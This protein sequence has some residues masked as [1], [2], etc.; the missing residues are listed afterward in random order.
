MLKVKRKRKGNVVLCD[1]RSRHTTRPRR[2]TKRTTM[3]D[4]SL[5]HSLDEV[6]VQVETRM[7]AGAR[8]GNKGDNAKQLFWGLCVGMGEGGFDRKRVMI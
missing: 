7:V 5:V 1:L 2:A 8:V 4:R 3:A 6:K